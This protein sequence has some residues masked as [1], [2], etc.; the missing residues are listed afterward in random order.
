MDILITIL[1]LLICI[2]LI[3]AILLQSGKGGGLASSLGGGMSS[4]SV[5]GGRTATT[6]LTKATAVLA[7]AFML[8]CLLQSF[9]YDAPEADNSTA[10][11][12]VLEQSGAPVPPP[13]LSEGLLEETPATTPD[14]GEAAGEPAPTGEETSEIK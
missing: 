2:F 1:H 3:L 10:T 9:S 6:F 7:A 13:A 11:E 5:L 14:A 12:R 4:S 8:I